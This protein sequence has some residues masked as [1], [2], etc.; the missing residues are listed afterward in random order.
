M[1][2]ES[3]NLAARTSE[4][5]LSSLLPLLRVAVLRRKLVWRTAVAILLLTAAVALILPDHYTAMVVLMP[6]QQGGASGAAMMAQLGSLGAMASMG[7]GALGIKNPNDM[8]IALLRSRTVENA[9]VDRFHLQALYHRKYLSSARR[10]WE[11]ATSADNGL[12][13][14]LIRIS[15]TDTDPRRAADLAGGWVD[16]YRRFAATLA[17]TEAAQRRLFFE[18][19]LNAAREAM[20]KA[21]EEMKLTQQRTGVVELEGQ[22]RAMIASAAL[23]RAQVAAKQVEVHAMREFAADQNPDLVRSEQELSSLEGQLSS[24][25]VSNDRQSGDLVT[26]RGKVSE[27]GVD[28]ARALR[29]L[30][31]REMVLELLTRQY[32]G[33]RVDEARQGSQVE[34][35]DPA[36]VP[37]RPSSHYRLWI[38]AGGLLGALPLSLL[39]ALL[40]EMVGI[41]LGHRRRSG[42]WSRAIEGALAGAAL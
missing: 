34:I 31:Y 4:S 23:I 24:M 7:G 26:P 15:V 33:A 3:N 13:D 40:A 36:A 22:E 29:E 9:M 6:P 5:P 18:T 35:V 20:A 11:Q 30:K 27:A 25:N 21:E 12:K 37:D 28:Y 42:S 38:A 16:E 32:E 10:R 1:Q 14:G 17:V 2:A 39:T 19:Q 8:Q 41:V